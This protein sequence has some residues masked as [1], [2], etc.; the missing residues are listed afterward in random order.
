MK[1]FLATKELPSDSRLVNIELCDGS[2]KKARSEIITNNDVKRI[3]W[4]DENGSY[5]HDQVKY[6]SEIQ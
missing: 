6:W 4:H 2:R 1:Q 5:I 3:N